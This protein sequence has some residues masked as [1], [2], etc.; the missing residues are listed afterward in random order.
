MTEVGS[1]HQN[2]KPHCIVF[3]IALANCFFGAYVIVCFLIS[4]RRWPFGSLH[5]RET[6][7]DEEGKNITLGGIALGNI[8]HITQNCLEDYPVRIILPR[9]LC[10]CAEDMQAP[11]EIM[12]TVVIGSRADVSDTGTLVRCTEWLR[13]ITGGLQPCR[14]RR[15]AF[16]GNRDQGHEY[17]TKERSIV[18]TGFASQCPRISAESDPACFHLRNICIYRVPNVYDTWS[19]CKVPQCVDPKKDSQ[20]WFQP[21]SWPCRSEP[22]SLWDLMA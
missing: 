10:F 1:I 3:I 14:I 17:L 7:R 2:R 21:H 6:L 13:L 16:H 18:E 8:S 22:R 9:Y 12:K 15:G 5:M 19:R 11:I 20:N 4:V